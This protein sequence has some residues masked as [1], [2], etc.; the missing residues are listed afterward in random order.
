MAETIITSDM[1]VAE[2]LQSV[3]DAVR[4]FQAHGVNPLA[5]CGPNIHFLQMEEAQG[6]CQIERWE[7][8]L[9]DLNRA[10]AAVV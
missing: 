3:P 5:D 6:R 10:A 7:E 8:L 2:V 4:L 1:T 9:T